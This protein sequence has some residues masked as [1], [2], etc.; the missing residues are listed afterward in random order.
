MLFIIFISEQILYRQFK[1]ANIKYEDDTSEINLIPYGYR[2]R[3]GFIVSSVI[4]FMAAFPWPIICE[5]SGSA[6]V[7]IAAFIPLFLSLFY[8]FPTYGIS[9]DYAVHHKLLQH[10]FI[11]RIILLFVAFVTAMHIWACIFLWTSLQTTLNHEGGWVILDNV[12]YFDENG[13]LILTHG[14]FR[15]Y[16]RSLYTTATNMVPAGFGDITP[17]NIK[18]T[19]VFILFVYT[20]YYF[21]VIVLSNIKNFVAEMT[22][23]SMNHEQELDNITQY[24]KYRDIPPDLQKRV[25]AFYDYMFH[26]LEGLDEQDFIDELPPS[27]K[28]QV[29]GE[30]SGTLVRKIPFLRS[31]DP[32]VV[33]AIVIKLKNNVYSPG[34]LIIPRGKTMKTALLFSRGEIDIYD[35]AGKV[36][37]T[38]N[39][40]QGHI[41]YETACIT[42]V[43]ATDDIKAKSYCEV[44]ELDQDELL[45]IIKNYIPDEL[46]KIKSSSENSAK[47]K[48]KA[49][50]MLGNSEDENK[51]LYTGWKTIFLPNSTFR[52]YWGCV[53]AVCTTYVI[54]IT[55]YSFSYYYWGKTSF[56][57][58]IIVLNCIADLLF[59][60][61]VF[62]RMKYFAYSENGIAIC[63]KIQIY[64]HYKN[65][66]PIIDI[67][68]GIPF[69]YLLCIYDPNAFNFLRVFK[70]LRCVH[71]GSQIN[72]IFELLRNHGIHL[73]IL[74][75]EL[76]KWLFAVYVV[77]HY[78]G[79]IFY[80]VGLYR[81]H[82][83]SPLP[84][85]DDWI[86][87]DNMDET[88]NV[89]HHLWNGWAG[90]LRCVY[91]A[92]VSTTSIGYGDI[93]P[94]YTSIIETL[95]VSIAVVLGGIGYPVLLGSLASVLQQFGQKV[96]DFKQH[97][98][99]LR[100][101]FEQ[102]KIEKK[103]SDRSIEY[104]D[105]IW[106]RQHGIDENGIL[107]SLPLPLR[108]Q[109]A[110]H[111]LHQHVNDVPFLQFIEPQVMHELYGIFEPMIFLPDD[112]I[113]QPGSVGGGMFM[114]ERGVVR[115]TAEDGTALAFLSAPQFIGSGAL[116]NRKTKFGY[117]AEGYC[118]GFLLPRNGTL[119]ILDDFPETALQLK[120][121][122]LEYETSNDKFYNNITENLK[123]KTK[124]N[125]ATGGKLERDRKSVV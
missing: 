18:E 74:V 122:I 57:V 41:E 125:K 82:N 75:S 101:Y 107:S 115:L 96:R 4:S 94:K 67:I 33:N 120:A 79:T 37:Q 20:G 58:G 87:N 48:Q 49:M 11:P 91:W 13:K 90:Y 85:T 117:Y 89:H 93:K 32:T 61:D 104:C 35:R 66:H 29:A 105:Y 28:S 10:I 6:D 83:H 98:T 92:I 9:I 88:L 45:K 3:R 26:L 63:N 95:Y 34:D 7:R 14:I 50:K 76:F 86:T 106:S 27:L 23:D 62:L 16:L 68:A 99:D 77:A 2:T 47:S 73:S 5:V 113:I 114:I 111:I 25:R 84:F 112:T 54:L 56:Y 100:L 116:I 30:I 108:T 19:V 21:Q 36:K 71:Y 69:E 78:L 53:L 103:I 109:I 40:D 119:D 65:S 46:E 118:D 110:D 42:P 60:V 39:C 72:A 97:M 22:S 102:N 1:R 51:K 31:L 81:M 70:L 59:I 124:I 24:L 44:Y 17:Q 121:D 12:A 80:Y 38:I 123:T 52:L 15:V 55:P 64:N 43:E 8:L